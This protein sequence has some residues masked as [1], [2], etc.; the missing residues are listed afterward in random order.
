MVLVNFHQFEEGRHLEPVQIFHADNERPK[1]FLSEKRVYAWQVFWYV[2][3]EKITK[4]SHQ[5]YLSIVT[6]LGKGAYSVE[7]DNFEATL[8]CIVNMQS[9]TQVNKVFFC[10]FC[11][12]VSS[13]Y[14]RT[15]WSKYYVH[16]WWSIKFI[17]WILEQKLECMSCRLVEELNHFWLQSAT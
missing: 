16:T 12:F 2:L 11:F 15:R 17:R 7:K 6:E 13:S 8:L 5:V 10:I 4:A 9:K 14:V 3:T 1:S